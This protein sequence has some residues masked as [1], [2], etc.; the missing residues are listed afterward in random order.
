MSELE[1]EVERVAAE[2]AAQERAN[3]EALRPLHEQLAAAEAARDALRAEYSA[4]KQ[5][6]ARLRG[7]L[8]VVADQIEDERE[9]QAGYRRQLDEP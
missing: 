7:E 1:A 9:R 5:R 4:R 8:R 2:L 6:L 3:E